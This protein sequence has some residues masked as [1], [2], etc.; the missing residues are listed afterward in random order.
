MT[1]HK[2]KTFGDFNRKGLGSAHFQELLLPCV[3]VTLDF[4]AV[5]PMGLMGR[6]VGVGGGVLFHCNKQVVSSEYLRQHLLTYSGPLCLLYQ[7]RWQ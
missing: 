2:E 5:I 6:G 4:T 7:G 3:S 1:D